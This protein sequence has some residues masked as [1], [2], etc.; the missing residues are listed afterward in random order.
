MQELI[1]KFVVILILFLVID[2]VWLKLVAGPKYKIS[3]R[4]IQG[5]DMKANMYMAIIVYLVMTVLLLLCLNKQFSTKELF[6][7]G[8]C[9]YAIYDFT[10]AA[11]FKKWDKLFGLFDSI[12]GGLLF[13]V[14]G[15]ITTKLIK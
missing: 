1:K 5:E 9:S 2:M 7:V 3:I 8:F 6:I 11:V 13:A 15:M 4:E 10:N 14:V 12:W